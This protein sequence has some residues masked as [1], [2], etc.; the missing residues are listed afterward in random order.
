MQIY[1]NIDQIQLEGPTFLTIGNFDGLHRGHQALLGELQQVAAQAATTTNHP[2][3]GLITFDPHPLAVL[4]PEQPLQLLTTP[5]ERLMLAAQLGIEI[6]VL[7]PFTPVIAQLD[8]RAFIRLLKRHLGMA[9]L[10]IGPD[11]A[12]G[13]NRSGDVNTLHA[14]GDEL[15]Y[16]LHVVKPVDW[17]GKPVRS[18]IVRQALQQGDVAEAAELLGRHYA[19]TG[20][21]VQGDQ[22]GRQI[23][24]PTANLQV[25]P[26]KL[27]PADGVYATRT[28]VQLGD[29]TSIFASATN[30]GMRPTVGGLHHRIETHLLDFPPDG[31]SDNLYGQTLT[32]EFV[33][34][35]R[36]EQRFASLTELV[37][38]IQ[39]DIGQTREILQAPPIH[40]P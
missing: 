29:T 34:R 7:Q 25:S 27:L 40:F 9:T 10:V 5:R 1:T 11:F 13:R 37:A 35:L 26:D 39:T 2:Q 32:V 18:S 12:L 14:L 17:Q 31:Q 19:I 8:A 16:T 22:R 20:E 24:V 21:V 30:L 33:A 38:Q 4:R 23:G 15:G 3:T 36:G 6:G 28:Q